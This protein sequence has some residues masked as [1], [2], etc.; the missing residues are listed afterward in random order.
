MSRLLVPAA[1]ALAVTTV[2]AQADDLYY[3][4]GY[5]MNCPMEAGGEGIISVGPGR[6]SITESHYERVTERLG[7]AGGWQRATWAC[8]A[9]GEE[10]GREQIDL[11]ITDARI[12]IRFAGD[13]SF[14]GARC[15]G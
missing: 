10:C 8:M 13:R 12:E 9:E 11:R 15:P 2:A 14:M 5:R 7:L 6:F 3:I 4:D 1:L